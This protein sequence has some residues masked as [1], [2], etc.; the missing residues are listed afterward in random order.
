MD[1]FFVETSVFR[2]GYAVVSDTL[3]FAAF[4]SL[5]DDTLAFVPYPIADV[6]GGKPE[7]L[8]PSMHAAVMR[9]RDALRDLI[10]RWIAAFPA[11]PDAHEAL[12]LVL[13]TNGDLAEGRSPVG[14]ALTAARRARALSHDVDQ[15]L[16]L[17]STEVRLLV[18]LGQFERAHAL[19]D[20]VLGAAPSQPEPAE[21]RR[22][23][24]LAALIGRVYRTAQL[25]RI[26]A[27]VDTPTTWDG[28]ALVDAP[29]AVKA[30]ALELLAYAALGGPVDS[31]RALKTRVDQSV[32][33]WAGPATRE[34][35][36]LAVLRVPVEL[37][38]AQLGLT[39]VHRQD[40][41]GGY[42]IERQWALAHGDTAVVRAD[43]ARIAALR[44]QLR[45]GDVPIDGTFNEAVL[46]LQIGDTAAASQLLDL[47]L[48]A[49]PTLGTYLLEE[50]P[51]AAALVRAMALRAELASRAGEQATARRWARVVITL[52][53]M[54]DPPLEPVLRRMRKL[55][56][57]PQR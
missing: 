52:W 30:V 54:G 21:A 49:L 18:K 4:P 37:A 50:T 9:N 5:A 16:R 26:S 25:L 41:V 22:F 33:S 43:I 28:Q 23:A 39:D 29:L 13:E 11:S 55:V 35:L 57:E 24:S 3:R 7:A 20:S 14:S 31:L 15:G 53:A 2:G 34:R 1:L 10:R 6:F 44:G 51:Q 38:F 45:P 27:A 8:P 46:L 42:L 32:S 40:A 56:G 47:S 12:T 36:R 19:A 48:E 17:A